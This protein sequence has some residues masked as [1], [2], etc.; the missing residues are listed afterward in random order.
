MNLCLKDAF[1]SQSFNKTYE[2]SFTQEQL[3]DLPAPLV[4]DAVKVTLNFVGENKYVVCNTTIS[5]D[6]LVNC[7]RCAK[8]YTLNFKCTTQKPV[9]CNDGVLDQDAIYLNSAY[10][11]NVCEE[12]YAQLHFEF[13]M[14]PLCSNDC[15]GLCPVCGCD[16]NVQQCS[17]DIR[18]VD[19]RLAVLKNLFDK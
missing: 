3:G 9:L 14:A 15:K 11:F 12:A 8:E 5:G 10:C 17:C 16:L 13:P 6:F 4:S 18:T 2:Y 19:P 7:S 1:S